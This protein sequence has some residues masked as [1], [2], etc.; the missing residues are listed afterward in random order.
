M[1]DG[2]RLKRDESLLQSV[3]HAIR[4]RRPAVAGTMLV[5]MDGPGGAG[6]SVLATSLAEK[7]I[8][9]SVVS[10]DDFYVP[11]NRRVHGRDAVL[12]PWT[13]IDVPRLLREVFQPLAAARHGSYR[14][15]DWGR[16]GM[17]E[18]RVVP[19]G[20]IVLVEGVYAMAPPLADCYHFKVW[21]ECPRKLRLARGLAR[22]GAEALGQWRD[23]WM[24]AEDRYAST[25][26]PM[27]RADLVLDW[28]CA[29][30]GD[31]MLK[32]RD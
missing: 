23:Q 27:D 3:L 29:R 24:P 7:D 28:S 5:A 6:K 20:G 12:A 15:Y 1:Q 19:P 14:R 11:L 18:R 13:N 10:I 22:D 26:R 32:L 4:S 21:M 17:A 8:H 25:H 9:I 31:P 30:D 16:D 2:P